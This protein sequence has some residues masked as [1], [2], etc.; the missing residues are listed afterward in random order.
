MADEVLRERRGHVELLTINRPEARNAINR[1]TAVAL[2]EALDECE[3]DDDVW[4]VVLTGAG[5]KAFSAG[6]DLKAFATGEFPITE[7][8][9]GG[10][11]K[12]NFTKPLIAA[13]NGAALA[14]GFEMMISCDMVVAADHAKFGIPEATRGLIAGGGGLIRLPKR[15]PL[16]VAYEL[17]LTGDPI[18][19][20]RAYELGLVN[21]VVPGD[22]VLDVAIALAERIAKNAPLAVRTS[23]DVMRRSI[24]LSEADAW[25]ANDEAFGMIGRSADAME[26]AVAFAEKREANWQGK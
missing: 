23:K 15:V 6:M 17:A 13:A 21:R 14:G 16:T 19:A 5:D 8:G 1:A 11:T 7:K 4:V 22:Q 24:E 10:I 25:T 20:A 3:I 2:S 9:F 26:G 12:R 18:D